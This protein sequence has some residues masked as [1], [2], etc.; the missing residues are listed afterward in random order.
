MIDTTLFCS[1]DDAVSNRVIRLE[2]EFD[3]P[4]SALWTMWTTRDGIR[5]WL[6]PDAAIELRVGG[7]FEILFLDASHAERGSEGCQILAWETERLL[8]F[9]WNAPP[10]LDRTRA[11]RT[12]VV[13]RL[14]PTDRGTRLEL[15]HTGWPEAAWQN[16]AQWP[17]TYAYF[18]AAWPRVIERLAAGINGD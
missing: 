8:V 13:L 17:A 15:V 7:R 12:W 2:R 6:A 4:P 18:D 3:A 9:S 16:D 5:A 14:E 1:H 10:H 11:R